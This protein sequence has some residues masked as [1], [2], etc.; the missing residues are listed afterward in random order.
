ME[1]R[2]DDPRRGHETSGESRLPNLSK[3]DYAR[4]GPC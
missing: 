2:S 1:D 3:V 4:L